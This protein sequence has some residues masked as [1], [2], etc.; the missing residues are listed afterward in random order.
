MYTVGILRG[1][2]LNPYEGQCFEKLPKYG[3]QPVGITT[4]DNSV[5]LS[6]IHFP[7]RVGHNFKTLTKGKLRPLLS[8]VGKVTKY[9]FASFNLRVFNLKKLTSDLDIIYSADSWYPYTYQAVKSGIPTIVMEWEN[10]PHN[11]EELPY[12]KIKKYNNEHA[13]HFVAITEKAK[14]ALVTEG[15]APY[16]ISVVPAG[17]DCERFKPT[18]RDTQVAE[19]IGVSKDSIRILFVGRLAP[20][21]GIFDLLNAFSMLRR[22]VQNVELLIVGSG[23]SVM[24]LQIS[25]FIANLKI[26]DK[27]KLLGSLEYPNMPP[28]HNLA[29]VFCLPSVPT[30]TWAEQFGYAM[31]EAMACGKPV[32]STSTGSIPEV[33]KDR[34]TGIFVKPNDPNGLE[35]ALEELIINKQ[36]R[37]TFGRNGREWVLEKFEANKIAGQLANIYCKFI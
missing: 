8:V 13:T 25:R 6:E 10:I 37:D 5:N 36:E 35:S 7:V 11:V 28:I 34:A 18:E 15:V 20:E 9:N 30:K 23:S 14:E 27:V 24:Q 29:D 21:K 3:F 2:S 19:K 12:R 1:P 4:Y 32:V 31:V 16:R 22:N 26:A 17:I 33:V